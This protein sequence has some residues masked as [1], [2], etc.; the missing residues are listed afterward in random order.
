MAVVCPPVNLQVSRGR[1]LIHK[2][3]SYDDIRLE[4]AEA[5]AKRRGLSTQEVNRRYD[6]SNTFGCETAWGQGQVVVNRDIVIV[7]AHTLYVDRDCSK[8]RPLNRCAFIYQGGVKDQLFAV[9]KVLN[10][11]G[12]GAGMKLDDKDDWAIIRIKGKLPKSVKPYAIP[13]IGEEMKVGDSLVEVGRSDG[14][15]PKN[16]PGQ[17]NTFPKGHAECAAL[18]RSTDVYGGLMQTNCPSYA[19][20]SGC[21]MLKDGEHPVFLGLLKA[22]MMPTSTCLAGDAAGEEG[23]FKKNCR[24]TAAVVTDG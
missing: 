7:P 11:G 19:G 16:S 18:Y 17:I 20:C 10:S 13:K 1:D 22:T 3:G 9:D 6:A 12:C 24:G 21:A 4:D 15:N 2:T 23:P 14:F 8:P 5:F